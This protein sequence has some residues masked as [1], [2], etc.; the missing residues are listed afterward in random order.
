MRI[1][2]KFMEFHHFCWCLM[3]CQQKLVR[4]SWVVFWSQ[5]RN[6]A[7]VNVSLRL[8]KADSHHKAM[9]SKKKH[10]RAAQA[11]W[12]FTASACVVAHT[13]GKKNRLAHANVP[14]FSC[15]SITQAASSKIILNNSGSNPC[16]SSTAAFVTF[17]L[18][19]SR[20]LSAKDETSVPVLPN[21]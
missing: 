3:D 7:A 14:W 8:S 9:C 12:L 21:D 17:L 1:S 10:Q 11:L 13:T 4:T 2:S 5:Q 16:S 6:N 15:T 20:K 19:S 18:A